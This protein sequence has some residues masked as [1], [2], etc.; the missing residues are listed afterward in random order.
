MKILSL[1]VLLALI[2]PALSAQSLE[3]R[4][5]DKGEM[6]IG[7]F[8]S[9]MFPQ[10]QRDTGHWYDGRK[11]TAEEH[12]RDSSVAIFIPK[13]FNPGETTNFAVYFHGWRNNI[14]STFAQFNLA[15]QF[16][17]S[18]IN[19]IL[20]LPEG[21]K[22]SPDSFGGKLEEADVFKHLIDDV[23]DLLLKSSKIKTKNIGS[24]IL[25][26]HSGAYRVMSF[27]LLRGGLTPHIKEVYLFDA[28]YGQTEKFSYWLDH[29]P[30]R[31]INIFTEEG[32]TKDESLSLMDDLQAWGI[33]F[34]SKKEIDV[35]ASDLLKNRILFIYSDLEHNDV[36]AKRNQFR[37]F[38]Q[39]SP[40]SRP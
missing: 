6:I 38:L 21:P 9:A 16:A 40:L 3:Q 5:A 23:L 1:S 4:Y 25:A 15:G 39:T 22:N 19:A 2:L 13:G 27:I 31:L 35:T 20:I 8:S 29:F 14:D 26:G 17:D 34:L 37:S 12:Y 36:I 32:G 30:G 33:P 11:Y 24:I 10:A 28:L 7:H 18:K